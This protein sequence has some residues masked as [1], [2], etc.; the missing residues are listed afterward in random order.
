MFDEFMQSV[1]SYFESAHQN[2][3][4]LSTPTAYL[5]NTIEAPSIAGILDNTLII[6][7]TKF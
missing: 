7:N 1:P 4:Q 6:K 5:D 2:A 3:A